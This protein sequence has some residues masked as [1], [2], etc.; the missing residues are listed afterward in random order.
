[1]TKIQMKR[2]SFDGFIQEVKHSLEKQ[3]SLDLLDFQRNFTKFKKFVT[4][5][6]IREFRMKL[7]KDLLENEAEFINDF[8]TCQN[9]YQNSKK[10][11]KILSPEEHKILFSFLENGIISFH[12]KFFQQLTKLVVPIPLEKLKPKK[13]SKECESKFVKLSPSN[14]IFNDP[15]LLQIKEDYDVVSCFKYLINDDCFRIYSKI[16]KN[17]D[18]LAHKTFKKLRGDKKVIKVLQ[19]IK[20]DNKSIPRTLGYDYYFR[21]PIHSAVSRLPRYRMLLK[22]FFKNMIDDGSDIAFEKKEKLKQFYFQISFILVKLNFIVPDN[23]TPK[24]PVALDLMLSNLSEDQP[25]FQKLLKKKRE[26]VYVS[27]FKKSEGIIELNFFVLKDFI[28]FHQDKKYK[29][30]YP[31]NQIDLIESYEP[32]KKKKKEE[33]IKENKKLLRT[34]T[35]QYFG[36]K[37]G[38]YNEKMFFENGETIEKFIYIVLKYKKKQILKKRKIYPTSET[39]QQFKR[40]YESKNYFDLTVKTVI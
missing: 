20:K 40:I 29:F 19:K 10:L 27:D 7:V 24:G 13:K 8:K 33:I 25:M 35:I 1:M 9:L 16:L 21:A 14:I 15:N 36:R 12:E 17:Y 39:I 37:I 23:R 28:V 30:A 4:N 26:F 38:E 2:L 3:I 22:D 18:K 11:Q 31:I 32:E 34:I 5:S 6:Q